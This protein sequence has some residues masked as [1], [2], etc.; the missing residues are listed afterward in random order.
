MADA[1]VIGGAD[2]R[3]KSSVGG[4]MSCG[5]G[6]DHVRFTR[7]GASSAQST[8]VCGDVERGGDGFDARVLGSNVVA[9]EGARMR[10]DEDD[11]LWCDEKEAVSGFCMGDTS[12]LGSTATQSNERTEGCTELSSI[13]KKRKHNKGRREPKPSS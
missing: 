12:E 5:Q 1:L 11:E 4:G 6:G 7:G 2:G 9:E 13:K 3:K 10:R 8:E